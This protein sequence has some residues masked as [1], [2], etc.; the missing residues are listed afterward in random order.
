MAVTTLRPNGTISGSGNVTLTSA[1]SAHAATNDDSD[2]SYFRKSNSISGTASIVLAFGTTT[3]TSSQL[4]RRF[5]VRTRAQ[6]PSSAGKVNIA[7]GTLA[8]GFY[9]YFWPALALRGANSTAEYTGAW[10]TPNA[11][12]SGSELQSA[13]NNLRVQVTEY[14]DSTDRAYIYELYIDLDIATAST[15]SVSAPTGTITTTAQP[16]VEWSVTDPDGDAFQ[17]YQVRIFTD[18]QYTAAGFDPATSTATYDSGAVAGTDLAL[19]VPDYLTNDTYRA[20]VRSAKYVNSS[21]L[22]SAYAY[23]TFTIS[24]SPPT[25]P[26]I[27]TSYDAIENAV[28]LTATGAAAVGFDSQVFEL[29]RSDDLGTTWSTVRYA[30]EL[31]PNASYIAT[32]ID[33]EAARGVTVEYRARAIGY[34]GDDVQ[35]SAWGATATRATTNNGTWI[36]KTVA[37]SP[38]VVAGARVIGPDKFEIQEQL[39]TFRPLGRTYPV[40]VS[41]AIGGQDG[42]LRVVTLSTA[43]YATL[44]PMI[45]YRG[46]LLVQDPFGEQRF[47]RVIKRTIDRS[48]AAT[49]PRHD[50]ELAYLEVED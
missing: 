16:T 14:K 6:T 29:Q 44:Q 32:I 26:T 23:S 50:I 9:S 10:Q 49:N 48:G 42:T 24:L 17:L 47:I 22:W 21:A 15:V 2:S 25:A 1:A 11:F 39:G 43:E 3:I 33:H 4:L 36:L 18:A 37:R 46:T 5:R 12:I 40:V 41:Q 45:V 27:T 7:P 13:V 8:L 20:Y 28:T 30:D 38:L 19:T 34:L 31:A 35:V